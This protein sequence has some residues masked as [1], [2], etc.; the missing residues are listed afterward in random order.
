MTETEPQQLL[1]A[2]EGNRLGHK[3]LVVSL[4]ALGMF[5]VL[6]ATLGNA[7]P[8]FT[9]DPSTQNAPQTNW[10]A[11]LSLLL[12]S[13]AFLATV[14]MAAALALLA[15]F[16]VHLARMG[17]RQ[18]HRIEDLQKALLQAENASVAKS[19]FLSSVSHDIRTPLNAVMG[20]TCIAKAHTNDQ[21]KVETCLEKI[22]CSS[23]H[24]L[25]LI[26]DV[27]DLSKI[28]NGKLLLDEREFDLLALVND[29][30]TLI[31]PQAKDKRQQLTVTTDIEHARVVG[32]ALR[33]KQVLL[34]LS[35]NAVKYTAPEG[36][37]RV[38]V[39]EKPSGQP[40]CAVYRLVVEDTGIGMDPEFVKRIFTPYE[41][42]EAGGGACEGTGLGMAIVKHI[43][44]MMDGDI[45]IESE[46]GV[47]SRFAVTLTL[48]TAE[49]AG[50]REEAGAAAR[51]DLQGR[52]LLAE[53][54]DLNREIVSELLGEYGVQV[55]SARDGKE[56][57]DLVTGAP[58]DYYDLV[59]M[60]VKMPV[61]DGFEA[62]RAICSA[63]RES[64]RRRPP[65]V[66]MTANAFVEDR[67]QALAAGMD[68]FVSKPVDTKRIEAALMTYLA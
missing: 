11:S 48:A 64:R 7:R 6:L 65:I 16:A 51:P 46:L 42:E 53:D 5:L 4:V 26:N 55:E 43:V 59:F 37:V 20:L 34:N 13:P 14:L 25:G 62:T 29:L 23:H 41:R 33:M 63:C 1:A 67:N 52:V 54:N 22:D 27:L 9:A 68:G 18:Q 45:A 35:S 47:G 49:D 38:S 32:D 66:A 15:G 28:E 44:D 30:V 24:L 17:R 21:D 39:E 56:A 8:L 57:L 60:D 12:E 10:P 3:P 19:Q 31:Q 2:K 61:M 58:E 36:A 40:Q 50:R